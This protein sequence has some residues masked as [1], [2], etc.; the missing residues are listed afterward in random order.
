MFGAVLSSPC[1]A[2][3]RLITSLLKHEKY[4]DITKCPIKRLSISKFAGEHNIAISGNISFDVASAYAWNIRLLASP[5][6]NDNIIAQEVHPIIQMSLLRRWKA[7]CDRCHACC[8][9]TF[10]NLLTRNRPQWLIDT[11]T[12]SLVPGTH[13]N[14]YV[15]LSY[16]WGNITFFTINQENLERLQAP[17]AF[18]HI[19]LPRT[20]RDALTLIEKLGERYCWVDS[21][22]IVQDDRKAKYTEIENMSAIF[23]NSSFTIIAACGSNA[24]SGL[25]GISNPRK[26]DQAIF[27]VGRNFKLASQ[28][29]IHKH[30]NS[31]WNTRAWTF[32]ENLFSR[33]R[34]IF[35]EESVHWECS[36]G[37]WFEDVRQLDT[38]STHKPEETKSQNKISGNF[39][40]STGLVCL[41]RQYNQR[42]LTYEEDALSAF[43]GVMLSLCHSFKHG[44]LSG[45][46]LAFF[47][48]A[49]LWQPKGETVRRVSATDTACLPSWSWAGWKCD[50]GSWSWAEW[51]N[52]RKSVDGHG[53]HEEEL[54]PLVQWFYH[55]IFTGLHV[56]IA[57]EW[58]GYRE[59]YL[60]TDAAPPGGWTKHDIHEGSWKFTGWPN[61]GTNPQKVPRFFYKHES[62]PAA[63]FWYP[64]PCLAPPQSQIQSAQLS[65]HVIQGVAGYLEHN[66]QDHSI[67]LW[68]LHLESPSAMSVF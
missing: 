48:I 37:F 32:Q 30:R 26:F 38:P 51:N 58:Y 59:K 29:G 10:P 44:F 14:D 68:L 36:N 20:I 33:R 39:P 1:K 7:S 57:A 67:L 50:L 60:H 66:I 8:K 43:T 56:P 4:H 31:T 3:N 46:P 6:Q 49:I 45:L 18:S 34:M 15:T 24:D 42:D 9:S 22:C 27:Q 16:V 5:N 64:I 25:P 23:A 54:I 55:H 17:G 41:L 52:Y 12:Q 63:K 13:S 35:D 40:D 11:W 2:H 62:E 47:D 28:R 19:A 53:T 21:L 65:Y 61:T